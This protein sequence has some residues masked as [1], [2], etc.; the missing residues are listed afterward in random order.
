MKVIYILIILTLFIIPA[1]T[2]E[3]QSLESVK[4]FSCIDLPQS[5]N[6]TS[7]IVKSIQYPNKTIAITNYSM[8]RDG[9][10]FTYRKFCLTSQL[11]IYIV[12][13]ECGGITYP[14]DF[15]V[16]PSGFVGTL[17]FY[18]II[19]GILAG[20]LILGFTIKDGWFVV[21]SGMGFISLGIYSIMNGIAGF[22]DSLLTWGTSLFFIGIGAYLA[23]NSA[24]EMIDEGF[25]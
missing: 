6:A 1:I 23:I 2:A 10:Y 25:E 16:T 24:I 13:T 17:G 21:F 4:Q 15:E 11:G 19:L 20:L 12:N 22:R 9:S 3:Q 8:D 14:Y 5:A 7:C 18:F